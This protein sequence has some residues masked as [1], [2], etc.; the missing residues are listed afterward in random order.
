MA[1]DGIAQGGGK[2][3]PNMEHY[4]G[5][6][7]MLAGSYPCLCFIILATWGSLLSDVLVGPRRPG[8]YQLSSGVTGLFTCAPQ[9][10]PLA[11]LPTWAG[12]APAAALRWGHREVTRDD[13]VVW[14]KGDGGSHWPP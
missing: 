3:D 8:G 4:G 11:S 9:V 7:I 14:M 2:S 12:P 6:S 13:E 5:V 10:P 1:P